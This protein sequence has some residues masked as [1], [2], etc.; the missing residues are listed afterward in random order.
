MDNGITGILVKSCGLPIFEILK[1]TACYSSVDESQIEKIT[2]Q[3]PK[4]F[5]ICL[6]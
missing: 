1:L 3:V 4:F 6:P 5:F 2:A